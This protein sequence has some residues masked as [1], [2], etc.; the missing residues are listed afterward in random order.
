MARLTKAEI[1]ANLPEILRALEGLVFGSVTIDVRQ[2]HIQNVSKS[3]QT[4]TVHNG[5]KVG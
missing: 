4:Y 2:G 3:E 5:R 1:D